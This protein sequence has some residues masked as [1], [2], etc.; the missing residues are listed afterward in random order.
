MENESFPSLFEEGWIRPQFR[1][2]AISD[3]GDGVVRVKSQWLIF[4]TSP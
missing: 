3:G 2:M 4:T 1:L